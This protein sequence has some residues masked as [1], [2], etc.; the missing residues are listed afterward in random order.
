MSNLTVRERRLLVAAK[1]ALMAYR[2]IFGSSW[3]NSYDRKA[4]C[5]L[6]KEIRRLER[7]GG[8]A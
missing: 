1:L 2:R 5:R 7:S 4:F 6:D 3:W 8:T